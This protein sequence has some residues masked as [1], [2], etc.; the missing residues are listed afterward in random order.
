VLPYLDRR[1]STR[2]T[3]SNPNNRSSQQQ[4]QDRNYSSVP[5]Q[6]HHGQERTYP[7]TPQQQSHIQDR[8]YSAHQQSLTQERNYSTTPQRN[9]E[10]RSPSSGHSQQRFSASNPLVHERKIMLSPDAKEFCPSKPPQTN[11]GMMNFQGESELAQAVAQIQM[12]NHSQSNSVDYPQSPY[13][14]QSG[15]ESDSNENLEHTLL[16]KVTDAIADLTL[17]PANFNRCAKT[18]TEV[19]RNYLRDTDTLGVVVTLLVEQVTRSPC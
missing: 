19:L 2:S 5:H 14:N 1:M 13:S 8:N 9:S 7:T 12:L 10:S 18:I 11:T 15:N 6:Q 17:H 4:A 3:N 16:S